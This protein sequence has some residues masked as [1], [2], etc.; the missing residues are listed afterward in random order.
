MTRSMRR[1]VTISALLS[2]MA[3]P[4]LG[5][6]G[7]AKAPS[8]AVALQVHPWWGL[9]WEEARVEVEWGRTVYRQG[10]KHLDL[11]YQNLWD[12][13]IDDDIRLFAAALEAPPFVMH[14]HG[15]TAEHHMDEQQSIYTAAQRLLPVYSQHIAFLVYLTSKDHL[16]RL[17]EVK[18]VMETSDGKRV[19]PVEVSTPSLDVSNSEFASWF[20][21]SHGPMFPLRDDAGNPYVTPDT[22]WLRLWVITLAQRTP[23]TWCVNASLDATRSIRFGPPVLSVQLQAPEALT[24]LDNRYVPS[25]FQMKAVVS[26]VGMV[27]AAAGT[28]LTLPSGLQW[29]SS[30]GESAGAELPGRTALVQPG[31]EQV[32]TWQ[33]VPTGL[34]VGSLTAEVSADAPRAEVVTTKAAITVPPINPELRFFPE[35]QTVPLTVYGMTAIIPVEIRLSPAREFYG[36]RFTMTYDPKVIE[37]LFTS[38][39]VAFIEQ[40][41]LL[42]PWNSGAVDYT[43]GVIGPVEGRRGDA[44]ALTML[45]ASLF[46]VTFR[47]VAPGKSPL[48]LKEVQL[49][50]TGGAKTK[51]KQFDGAVTV[52]PS[53]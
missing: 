19:K 48:V 17:R 46:T 20:T 34:P 35:A 25:P 29:A 47:A 52:A 36:A 28:R 21:A 8:G 4:A 2:I 44:P 5:A 24:V 39:G 33:L 51:F 50:E 9:S 45:N 26:N 10:A 7:G 41:K 1:V 40:G 42:S 31:E 3:L 18:F 43:A 49:L 13:E 32:F 11:F 27:T 16:D 14:E 53:P 12:T 6:L 30:A 38:R 22:K 37:P 15:W 23:V